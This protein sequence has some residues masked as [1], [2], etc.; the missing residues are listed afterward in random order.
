VSKKGPRR[1]PLCAE[2]IKVD[3]TRCRFC[4]SS[5]V[6]L[7]F[8]ASGARGGKDKAGGSNAPWPEPGPDDVGIPGIAAVAGAL[9]GF[10]VGAWFGHVLPPFVAVGGAVAGYALARRW[11]SL[12][13]GLDRQDTSGGP[14]G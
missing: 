13:A 1:C 12:R 8:D 2:V 10:G 4:G 11:P 14:S 6:N 5:L 3:A 7:G 9:L